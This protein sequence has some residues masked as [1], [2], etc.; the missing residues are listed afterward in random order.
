M[1]S[2]HGTGA[3]LYWH[4]IITTN[5]PL[6]NEYIRQPELRC[7]PRWR[8]LKVYASLWNDQAHLKLPRMHDLSPRIKWDSSTDLRPIL[9]ANRDWAEATFN[10]VALRAAW[11][12]VLLNLRQS[13]G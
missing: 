12:E 11:A 10:P 5:Y 1:D 6:M 4:T 8:N 2:L 3:R 7:Q 9:A 13:R